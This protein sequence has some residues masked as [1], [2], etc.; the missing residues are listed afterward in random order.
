MIKYPSFAQGATIGIT[1]P[2]SGVNIELHDMFKQACKRM[3]EKGFKIHCGET[4]WMQNKAKSAPAKKRAEEFNEMMRSKHVDLI[5]PPWGGELLIEMLE[6]VDFS[7]MKEKWILGY[8][9]ISGL[10]LATTLITGMAT[11][12]GTNLV[13]LRGDYSDE[14]TDMWESVLTTKSGGSIIQNSSVKYQKKWNHSDPSP[15]VFHLTEE[16]IWRTVSKTSVKL[17]G[18]LLG[19]CIDIIRHLIGTPYGDVK[20]FRT[21]HLHDEPILWYLENCEMSTADL[22]RSLTQMKF[23]GWF[24]NCSGIMFGRSPANHPV[25]DY[26]IEDVYQDLSDETQIPIACDIDCGHIP[27]QITFINGAFAEVEVVNG[28]GVVKQYF[29]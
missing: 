21:K 29:T 20:G 17:H 6:F 26:T 24:E 19:G 4:V 5:I 28:K 18:R 25:E 22:K 13:D 9:D 1:A 10:L 3:E 15:M 23:A 14:T 12:H 11:A 7:N 8:S 16:T 27:P 2:S